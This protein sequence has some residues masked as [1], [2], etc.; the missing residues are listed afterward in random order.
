MAQ[1]LSERAE[2]AQTALFERYDKLNALWIEAE[3]ELSAIH[4]PNGVEFSYSH[5]QDPE[6]PGYAC[7]SCLG[8]QKI[9]G[10]WRICHGWSSDRY[11]DVDDW[12][13]ITE[14]SAAIRATVGRHLPKLR[15]AV[16][17]SAE[18]FIPIVE[19]GIDELRAA[20][21]QCRNDNL[22]ELLAERAK[23]NGKAK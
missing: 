11:P 19:K 7:Y 16:V 6:N 14:C 13:P 12:T 1:S 3:D 17:K 4:I 5:C 21:N 9:K 8:L 20:L 10:K 23:L 18:N 15:E 2:A 22:P